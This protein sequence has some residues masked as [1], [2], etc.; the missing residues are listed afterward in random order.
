MA[1]MALGETLSDEGSQHEGREALPAGDPG[2]QQQAVEQDIGG[3]S[4]KMDSLG[5]V[6]VNSDGTISRITNWD[7]MT[8][9]EKK[10]ALKRIAKRNNERKEALATAEAKSKEAG[11]KQVEL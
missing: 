5:P 4:I 8:E 11:G 10:V 2:S 9:H 6:I 1:C 3:A 7:I